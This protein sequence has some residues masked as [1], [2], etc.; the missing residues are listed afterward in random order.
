MKLAL[1]RR[2]L[3]AAVRVRALRVF[4]VAGEPSG[5]KIGSHLMR[6]LRAE[7]NR[8]VTFH[9]VGGP[10]MQIEGLQSIFPMEDLSV[11]GFGEVFLALPRLLLRLRQTIQSARA[12]QPDV[13]V[14][15]DSKGFCLRVLR[16]LASDRIETKR[17]RSRGSVS[18]LLVQYVAPSA[19]AFRD[20][21]ARAAKLAGVVD[22]LLLLLP[23][24]EHLYEAAGVP[25]TFVGHPSFEDDGEA[26]WDRAHEHASSE[27]AALREAHNVGVTTPVLTLLPGSRPAEVRATLPPMLA[28]LETIAA[29]PSLDQH[30][31]RGAGRL[32]AFI[33]TT[34][35]LRALVKEVLDKHRSRALCVHIID[36]NQRRA[37][38]HGSCLALACCGTVNVE[39]ALA[40]T[41]QVVVWRS[42]LLTHLIIQKMLR[43]TVVHASLPNILLH[44]SRTNTVCGPAVQEPLIPECLMDECSP[45]HIATAAH[46]LLEHPGVAT[47]QITNAAHA[48][49]RLAR[50]SPTGQ[51][52]Q[53]SVI[54]ARTL[55]C[56]VAS[57]ARLMHRAHGGSGFQS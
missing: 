56:L 20:A 53:P 31:R 14:G 8:Q 40:S 27:A 19:W 28:A 3:C 32:S 10:H 24:E 23:F 9:G 52:I 33:P 55:L 49:Q 36:Q 12:S 1:P 21:H 15:I 34:E 54:A 17:S 18:P 39:L 29:S 7:S 51:A 30:G 43:P 48:M 26:W 41:P 50:R 22:H 13:V 6:A 2:A 44:E 37:A 57:E 46:R 16:A 42:S 35:G 25:C 38:Y 47:H 11:M 45:E 4:L 5:D